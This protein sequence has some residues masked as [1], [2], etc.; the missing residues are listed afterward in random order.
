MR[1]RHGRYARLDVSD[2]GETLRCHECGQWKRSLGRHISTRHGI[3]AAEYRHRHGIPAGQSLASPATRRRFAASPTY[4]PAARPGEPSPNTATPP[5]REPRKG[6]KPPPPLEQRLR[7]VPT[8]R[9]ACNSYASGSPPPTGCQR[10]P[11][12]TRDAANAQQ[13]TTSS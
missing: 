10:A 8:S 7:D 13:P 6:Q 11:A 4:N 3:S 2:D 5:R 1:D 9:P 12:A